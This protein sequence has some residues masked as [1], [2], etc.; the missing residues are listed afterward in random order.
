[1]QDSTSREALEDSQTYR[2]LSIY[3]HALTHTHKHSTYLCRGG[4]MHHALVLQLPE[5]LHRHGGQN[6]R[7]PKHLCGN[8]I[9]IDDASTRC[10]ADR[11][12][13]GGVEVSGTTTSCPASPMSERIE[14]Q[15]PPA[16]KAAP[17]KH[18]R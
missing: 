9:Q 3:A 13:Y 16:L 6:V 8:I 7:R 4:L 2:G 11:A 5:L 17:H 12:L 1:M 14:L 15:P 18:T 10:R